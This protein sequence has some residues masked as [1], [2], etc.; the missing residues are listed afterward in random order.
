[1]AFL[2]NNTVYQYKRVIVDKEFII[3]ASLIMV[4]I[5]ALSSF[6]IWGISSFIPLN[7]AEW[8]CAQDSESGE[9]ISYKKNGYDDTRTN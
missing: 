1:M 8:H 5:G 2:K 3:V 7:K 9:C 4:F 6:T